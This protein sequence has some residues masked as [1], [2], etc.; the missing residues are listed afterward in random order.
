VRHG[1]DYAM[2]RVNRKPLS[3]GSEAEKPD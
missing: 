2:N 1:L 3:T